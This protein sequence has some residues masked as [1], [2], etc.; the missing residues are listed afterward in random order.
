MKTLS[1]TN[2][3]GLSLKGKNASLPVDVRQ[4]KTPCLFK[5]RGE[6]SACERGGDARRKFRIKPLKETDLG[7]AQAFFDPFKTPC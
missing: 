4:A 6:D 1:S 5:P 3:T 7:A 2:V